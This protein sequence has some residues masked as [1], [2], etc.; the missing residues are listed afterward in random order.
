MKTLGF[1]LFGVALVAMVGVFIWTLAA[2]AGEIP[3]VAWV[4]GGSLGAGTILLLAAAIR[5]RLKAKK[6]EQY[7]KGVDN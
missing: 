1:V 4:I 7:L 6:D 3:G 5:D 2:D